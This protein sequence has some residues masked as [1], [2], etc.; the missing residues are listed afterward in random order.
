MKNLL[1]LLIVLVTC[2]CSHYKDIPYFQN[3][4][5]YNGT[6]K[7]FLYDADNILTVIKDSK[8]GFTPEKKGFVSVFS[9]SDES[10]AVSIKGLKYELKDAMLDNKFP[11][12]VSNEFLGKPSEISVGNGTLLIIFPK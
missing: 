10:R 7:G 2:S 11:L 4:A 5:E 6:G 9:L 8:F 12:G 3:A 1:I